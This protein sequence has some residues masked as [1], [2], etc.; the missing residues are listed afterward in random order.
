M[1]EETARWIALYDP[2]IFGRGMGIAP[3]ENLKVKMQ[4]NINM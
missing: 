3:R 2:K 1:L 4:Q